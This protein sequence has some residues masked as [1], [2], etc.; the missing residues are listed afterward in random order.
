[1]WFSRKQRNRRL[2]RGHV[3][4]VKLRSAQVR[5]SRLRLGVLTFGVLFGTVLGLY[6]LWLAGAWVLDTLVYE[7]RAFAIEQIDVHTDGVISTDQLRRWTGV[8]AG[9]NL[10]ALDLAR[11]KRDLE[12][13][14]L[15]SSV[16]IERVLPRTLR[17]RVTEREAV[18]QINVLRPNPRGVEVAVVHLDP[19]GYVMLPLDPR[20][21]TTPINQ[22]DDPLP[23]LMGVNVSE[24]QPG[25]SVELP[26][27]QAA[28]RLVSEFA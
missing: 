4:D 11:V 14:P 13:V 8:K 17:I 6:L 19:E 1:M 16:S 18:A 7:N 3:L 10:L 26:Q 12:L 27:V 25:R 2:S 5:A 23:L 24:L 22:P 21:R 20:Q 28:L 15:I 9:E